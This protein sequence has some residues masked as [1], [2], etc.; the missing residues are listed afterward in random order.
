MGIIDGSVFL[1]LERDEAEI[2][3]LLGEGGV[4]LGQQ[5]GDGGFAGGAVVHEGGCAKIRRRPHPLCIN[6]PAPSFMKEVVQRFDCWR[7]CTNSCAPA[8]ICIQRNVRSVRLLRTHL[9][10]VHA[11]NLL[12]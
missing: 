12:L 2:A 8:R 11:L 5:R 1:L 4:V 6:P 3:V 7:R 10:I 9:N